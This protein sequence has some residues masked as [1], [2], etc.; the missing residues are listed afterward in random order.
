MQS[1]ME[2]ANCFNFRL[3]LIG[4]AYS[5]ILQFCRSTARDCDK[6]LNGC[7]FLGRALTICKAQRQRRDVNILPC[8]RL[9]TKKNDR[10]VLK[11]KQIKSKS[12]MQTMLWFRR[13]GTSSF[14]TSHTCTH[15]PHTPHLSI[16]TN[17]IYKLKFMMSEMISTPN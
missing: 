17:F 4:T 15:T 10:M 6:M 5:T 1:D 14:Y 11:T 2:A 9:M 3:E 7:K 8:W 16:I 13:K 12:F